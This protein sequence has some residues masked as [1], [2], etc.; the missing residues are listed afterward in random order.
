MLCYYGASLAGPMGWIYQSDLGADHVPMVLRAGKG[1][2]KNTLHKV[3]HR[4]R[5][6]LCECDLLQ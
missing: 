1:Y 3:A 4:A 2:E 6:G 5:G